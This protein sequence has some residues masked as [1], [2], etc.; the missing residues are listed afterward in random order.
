MVP[1]GCRGANGPIVAIGKLGD[2]QAARLID[3]TNRYVT[4]GFNDIHS[5]ADDGSGPRG[6]FRDDNPIRRSAPHLVSQ[7]II[8]VV[9]NPDGRSPWPL[10]DQ[11]A[12]L[13]K[14]GIGPNAMLLVGHGTVR[15][16]VMGQ[17]VRRPAKPDEVVRMRAL[18]KEV[19][20]QGAVGMS[21]G[22]NTNRADGARPRKSSNSRRSCCAKNL[23]RTL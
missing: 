22:P 21:A 14:N 16:R 23:W 1:G 18:V 17:D 12:Q 11:C 6:G 3:A 5:L 8:T 10:T 20:H 4:P 9:V 13:E 7:D 2:A 15:R 19:L